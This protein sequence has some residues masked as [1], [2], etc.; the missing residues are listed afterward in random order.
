[1]KEEILYRG[2]EAVLIRQGDRVLKRRVEK[3]YLYPSLGERLRKRRT[4]IEARLLTRAQSIISVPR[5]L[6][7]SE[8]TMEIA[9][10]FLDG[11]KLSV[12]LDDLDDGC[13]ICE[14]IGKHVGGLHDAGIIH[15]DLTTSNMILVGDKVFFID[16]GLGFFS[17]RTEDKAVDLHLIKEALEAR[18]FSRWKEYFDCVLLGYKVSKKADE[19][20]KRL[21]KVEQR[22]RYREHY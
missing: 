8:K 16:F 13:V 15:G 21:K 20:L 2:A 14:K 18:H 4:R 7:V 11:K 9:L 19:V 12:W 1:M 10:E 17:Q 5:V 3:G 22:G 6:H